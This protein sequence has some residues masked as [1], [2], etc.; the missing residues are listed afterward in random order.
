MLL[1]FEDL[2]QNLLNKH[3]WAHNSLPHTKVTNKMI[4]CNTKTNEKNSSWLDQIWGAMYK[5]FYNKVPS[6]YVLKNMH[7]MFEDLHQ[8]LLN[9]HEWASYSLPHT[10][11]MT[12]MFIRNTKTNEKQSSWQDQT[13]EPMYKTFFTAVIY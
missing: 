3:V 5:T 10:K 7:L 6:K 1:M 8:K 11:V 12:K 4:I 2:H 13:W 9:K